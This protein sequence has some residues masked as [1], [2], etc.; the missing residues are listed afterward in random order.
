MVL[1]L[2][3]V[4]ALKSGGPQMTVDMVIAKTEADGERIKCQW[5]MEGKIES[6]TFAPEELELQTIDGR[7]VANQMS[8]SE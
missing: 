3:D 2:G 1:K 7:P 6:A 5:F 8:S 4:V